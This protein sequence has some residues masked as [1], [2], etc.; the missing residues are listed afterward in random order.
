MLIT[1]YRLFLKAEKLKIATA[2][3]AGFIH[4]C[5]TIILLLSIGK[6]VELAFNGSGARSRA[7]HWLGI[8]LPDDLQFFYFFFFSV[9][10]LKLLAAWAENYFTKKAA[11]S[12]IETLRLSY[13]SYL[14]SSEK[15]FTEKPVSKLLV[16]F[17][18]DL[19]TLQRLAE[20]GC[21]GLIKDIL[22][23]LLMAYVLAGLSIGFSFI[24]CFIVIAGWL[25]NRASN[26]KSSGHLKK[27]RNRSGEV[28]AHIS[29]R[30]TEAEKNFSN[31][32]EQSEKEALQKLQQTLLQSKNSHLLR[33]SFIRSATPFLMYV[34]LG[35][36]MVAV[37]SL[38]AFELSQADVL[39]FLLLLLNLFSPMGRI[40]R[41]ENIIT[42]AKMG[43]QR[44]SFLKK[45]KLFKDKQAAIKGSKQK[46]AFF[47]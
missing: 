35:L 15:V 7:L 14:L 18:S 47:G 43:L 26:K 8:H 22:F 40:I 32:Q 36:V 6:Y 41:I 2:I 39:T 38:P 44:L 34:F 4:I 31:I 1:F 37:A 42:P 23:V 10:C 45:E 21:I 46:P 3:V 20:K 25:I 33:S 5:C 13:F 30:F 9:V 27:S 29:N 19:K 17:S 16:W 12:Y 24:I 11:T 28:L